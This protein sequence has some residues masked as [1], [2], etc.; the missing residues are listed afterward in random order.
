M[1]AS[2][3]CPILTVRL[4]TLGEPGL[5]CCVSVLGGEWDQCGWESRLS[6]LSSNAHTAVI[7]EPGMALTLILCRLS[8]Q[9]ST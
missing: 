3:P 5:L 1:A 9:Q 4:D 8:T 2:L 6:K 7:A